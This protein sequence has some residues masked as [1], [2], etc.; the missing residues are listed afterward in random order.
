MTIKLEFLDKC[1]ADEL[2]KFYLDFPLVPKGL[3]H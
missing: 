1:L 3:F 2:P